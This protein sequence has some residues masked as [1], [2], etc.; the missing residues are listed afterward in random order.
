MGT[1]FDSQRKK[2]ANYLLSGK[3]ITSWEA[4]QMFH[5]TRL[6]AVI[7]VLKNDYNMNIESERIFEE[8]TNYS[9]YW[10]KKEE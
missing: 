9:R 2:I 3:A 10:I 7:Y 1:K 4:I 6:S 5:C 8:G